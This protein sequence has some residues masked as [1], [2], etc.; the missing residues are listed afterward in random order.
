MRIASKNAKAQL[1]H[2]RLK[3]VEI[4]TQCVYVHLLQWGH[5]NMTVYSKLYFPLL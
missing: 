4:E 2:F 1:F 5:T 3:I